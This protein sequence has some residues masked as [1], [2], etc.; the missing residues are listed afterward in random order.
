MIRNRWFL[1]AASLSVMR[2]V[3]GWLLSVLILWF[4]VFEPIELFISPIIAFFLSL[5]GGISDVFDGWIARKKEVTS[6]WGS[7]FDPLADKILAI[8]LLYA[9]CWNMPISYFYALHA[10][11]FSP[12]ATTLIFIELVLLIGGFFRVKNKAKVVP[13]KA[14][15]A[16]TALIF[17]GLSCI[18]CGLRANS[19]IFLNLA[20]AALI[21]ACF[22][23][24]WS[25]WGYAKQVFNI[26]LQSSYYGR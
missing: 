20:L 22:L 15:R 5:V 6:D 9:L 23:G 25:I 8:P 12:L 4:F 17:V 18:F 10:D 14:G 19:E 1:I 26:N 21:A 13:G 11:A 24:G 3:A 2:F 7:W 16:T